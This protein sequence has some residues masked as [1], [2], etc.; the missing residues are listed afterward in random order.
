MEEIPRGYVFYILFVV[1]GVA[2]QKKFFMEYVVKTCRNKHLFQPYF[3]L[4]KLAQLVSKFALKSHKV[5]F[6]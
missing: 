4:T 2:T 6:H 3:R 5:N 1:Y